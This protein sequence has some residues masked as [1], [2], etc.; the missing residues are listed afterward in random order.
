MQTFL[1]NAI[2]AVLVLTMYIQSTVSFADSLYKSLLQTLRYSDGT[3]NY[4][5][6]MIKRYSLIFL[7]FLAKGFILNETNLSEHGYLYSSYFNTMFKP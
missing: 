3:S 2:L 5:L 1:Q 6:W 4:Q 7:F